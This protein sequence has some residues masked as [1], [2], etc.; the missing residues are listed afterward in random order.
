MSDVNPWE[1]RFYRERQ[2]RKEAE[3]LLEHKSLELWQTNQGLEET[4]KERTQSLKKALEIAKEASRSKSAFLANMSHEIRTPMNAIL[5]FN[6]LLLK[7][8]LPPKAQEYVRIVNASASGLLTIIN[9]ILD[10]SKIESGKME[11]EAD[12]FVTEDLMQTVYE[13]FHANA[14]DKQID[15]SIDVCPEV[16]HCLV[17]DRLRLQQVL[18]NLIS[19]AIK[20]TPTHEKVIVSIRL[21]A[22]DEATATVRFSVEDTGIG[23][24]K[25]AQQKIFNAFDQADSGVTRHFGGTGL[26]L[27]ISTQ[28]LKMMGS[29]LELYSIEGIGSMFWFDVPMGIGHYEDKAK[30]ATPTMANRWRRHPVRV[31]VADDAEFNQILISVLLEERQI[32]DVTIAEH[33]LEAI[34]YFEQEPFDL[35]LMDVSMPTMDGVTATRKIRQIESEDGRDPTPIIALTANAVKGDRESYLA[36]GMDDYLSKPLDVDALDRMLSRF[37][38]VRTT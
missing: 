16:P 32:H 33:G 29:S 1:K 22:S 31:L 23:I 9:D 7:S 28:L 15:Y 19:N 35:I 17:G 38:A 12:A 10:L 27:S 21:Q 6:E 34:R 4:I 2:A 18:S 26:G 37:L 20:F 24:P 5:G 25:A 8:D 30:T 13:L 3:E 14:R 36:A 11:L